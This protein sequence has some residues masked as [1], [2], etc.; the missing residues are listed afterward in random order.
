V[1]FVTKVIQLPMKV[2]KIQQS[3]ASSDR[4]CRMLIYDQSRE[5]YFEGELTPVVERALAGR[6]KAYFCYTLDASNQI[7]LAGEVPA[8]PW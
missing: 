3:L 7:V 8:Q 6:A 5:V 1:S 2:V 4:Q